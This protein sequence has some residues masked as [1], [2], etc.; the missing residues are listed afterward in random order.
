MNTREI[1]EE[2]Y[3]NEFTIDGLKK[4]K[5]GDNI[6]TLKMLNAVIKYLSRRDNGKDNAKED[7]GQI[8]GWIGDE[9]C[10][11]S[12]KE[13]KNIL[14][15]KRQAVDEYRSFIEPRIK[16][17][18]FWNGKLTKEEADELLTHI[19]LKESGN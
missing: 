15:I 11:E 6:D 14:L 19:N 17:W 18:I 3:K 2:I 10:K 13:S 16:E 9:H 7:R 12:L 8:I 4:P 1:I 5:G